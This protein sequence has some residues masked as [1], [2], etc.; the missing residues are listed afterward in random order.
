M[1]PSLQ[2]RITPEIA[3]ALMRRRIGGVG[4]G[5]TMPAQSQVMAPNP[6]GGPMGASQTPLPT[7]PQ[8]MP[9]GSVQQPDTQ[10]TAQQSSPSPG[11]QSQASSGGRSSNPD[12][13][14]MKALLQRLVAGL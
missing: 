4:G 12:V 2:S 11:G 1:N 6:M 13:V 10:A 7:S 9:A 3:E 8:A 5:N 14:L